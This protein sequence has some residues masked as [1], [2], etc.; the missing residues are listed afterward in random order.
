MYEF[1]IYWDIINLSDSG[2]IEFINSG[3]IAS[4]VSL[5]LTIFIFFGIRKIKRFYIFT[6]RVPEV[7]ESLDKIAS[8][9]SKHLNDYEESQPLIRLEL[10]K[11]EVS[12]K[13]LR[14]KIGKREHRKPINTLIKTINKYKPNSEN[15]EDL[16]D[17]YLDLYKIVSQIE[18]LQKD[19]KWEK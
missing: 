1:L 2:K 18:E 14:K 16:R 6:G 8:N 7:V 9:I 15:Q 11:A 4:I 17:I 13:S 19:Q 12:L 3:S 10:A 5:F